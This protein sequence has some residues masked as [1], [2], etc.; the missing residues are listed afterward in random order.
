MCESGFYDIFII[1]LFN[2][3]FYQKTQTSALPYKICRV[4]GRAYAIS[5]TSPLFENVYIKYQIVDKVTVCK[6]RTIS[7]SLSTEYKCLYFI[8]R[9]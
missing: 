7:I 4:S 5:L 1:S 8:N 3:L 6:Q 9:M 2:S